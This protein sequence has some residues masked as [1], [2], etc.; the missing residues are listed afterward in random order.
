M[1][2]GSQFFYSDGI[3]PGCGSDDFVERKVA[4]A[5]LPNVGGSW[6][7]EV[8]DNG[9]DEQPFGHR[10]AA[11]S[12]P[13][14]AVHPAH[15]KTVYNPP[16]FSWAELLLKIRNGSFKLR[17]VF[18][19]IH[20]FLSIHREDRD[21]I[22]IFVPES[23]RSF[24]RRKPGFRSLDKSTLRLAEAAA[25]FVLL[26]AATGTRIVSSWFF[27]HYDRNIIQIVIC[28]K[29]ELSLNHPSFINLPKT[30]ISWE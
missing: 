26:P 28:D 7:H 20:D 18:V 25:F 24:R 22:H 12:E 2:P 19:K 10:F 16:F 4:F 8:R 27:A 29:P 13:K 30:K 9:I 21:N 5:E 15:E 3:R 1:L 17:T 11:Y 23:A 6:L 14:V